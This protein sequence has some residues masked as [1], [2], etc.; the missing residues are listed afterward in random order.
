MR[1][2]F[3]FACESFSLYT[4][5]LSIIFTHK[6]LLSHEHDVN[7]HGH[8]H[9]GEHHEEEFG[10]IKSKHYLLSL[11]NT[12]YKPV[13]PSDLLPKLAGDNHA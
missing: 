4:G 3:D 11:E 7:I 12:G 10:D 6:P 9:R 8:L 2:G 5:G 13:L 1:N